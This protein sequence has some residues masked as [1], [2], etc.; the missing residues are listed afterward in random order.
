MLLLLVVAPVRLDA[1]EHPALVK[2][3]VLYNT[4]EF[5]GAIANDELAGVDPASQGV[6]ELARARARGQVHAVDGLGEELAVEV[7]K[8]RAERVRTA[9][10]QAARDPVGPV[11]QLRGGRRHAPAGGRAHQRMVE[12][13]AGG[14]S[15]TDRLVGCITDP[16]RPAG[17]DFPRDAGAAGVALSGP[18]FQC[19]ASGAAGRVHQSRDESGALAAAVAVAER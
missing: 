16:S 15:V 13:T 9:R 3:R 5:D 18:G 10:D 19:A 8:E 11:A 14:G 1:A 2:A 4:A 17:A 7:G 12:S 6:S